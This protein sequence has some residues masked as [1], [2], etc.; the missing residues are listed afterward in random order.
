M[1]RFISLLVA[2]VALIAAAVWLPTAGAGDDPLQAVKAATARY[3]SV[4]QAL[5]D[6]YVGDPFCVSSP[7]GGM[8]YHYVNEELMADDALDPARPE[9]LVYAPKANGSLELVAVEYW[10]RDAD[11]SLLTSGDRPSLFGQPFDGPMPGHTPTMPVH[12]DLHVWIYEDNP[13]G[14]FT[15][16][17][18]DVSCS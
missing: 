11:G 16:F 13:A 4:E 8:G 9:I 12:Y 3:N 5:K 2:L 17:N 6:G 15:A 10:K 7:A 14:T 18:P 1:I